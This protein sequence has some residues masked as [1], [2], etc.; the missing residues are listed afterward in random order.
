MKS[1][2]IDISFSKANSKWALLVFWHALVITLVIASKAEA[3]V[4][5]PIFMLWFR[6]LLIS[7]LCSTEG[8]I[9]RRC[10]EVTEDNC[11]DHVG[12]LTD[13]CSEQEASKIP[14]IVPLWKASELGEKIGK[15][16]GDNFLERNLALQLTSQS[17]L[18]EMAGHAMSL[19][20]EAFE[21][22]LSLIA[23]KDEEIRL[24]LELLPNQKNEV[25]EY[26]RGTRRSQ[27]HAVDIRKRLFA[28]SIEDYSAT[29][30]DEKAARELLAE[31]GKLF[32]RMSAYPEIYLLGAAAPENSR[33][34]SPEMQAF[35][36]SMKSKF[37]DQPLDW[38]SP[39][40]ARVRI[41]GLTL[42]ASG[43]SEPA[44]TQP[45]LSEE[46]LWEKVAKLSEALLSED[47]TPEERDKISAMEDTPK[48]AQSASLITRYLSTLCKAG[49]QLDGAERADFAL[50][51]WRSSRI[52]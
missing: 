26:L 27:L 6:P 4:P 17:C 7:G 2:R 15:C 22:S 45:P 12:K 25:I 28:K 9:L 52:M 29:V 1:T 19:P 51:M 8:K 41:L 31:L 39:A 14:L 40:S 42:L 13:Y 3:Q 36:A 46:A 24:L 34:D 50:L 49:S 18:S 44:R 30:G 35:A 47:F 23:A 33:V 20:D 43:R 37:K 11:S 5:R 48:D 32:S 21:K 10:F 38:L 16:V